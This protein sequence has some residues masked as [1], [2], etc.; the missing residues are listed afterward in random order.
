MADGYTLYKVQ[1]TCI[2]SGAKKPSE[3]P[4]PSYCLLICV[5]PL[6]T[7]RCLFSHANFANPEKSATVV[8]ATLL[9]LAEVPFGRGAQRRCTAA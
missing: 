5:D 3:V 4:L 2:E 9:R 7:I 6:S 8:G 1:R